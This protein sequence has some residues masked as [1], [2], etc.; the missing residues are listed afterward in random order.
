MIYN[1]PPSLIEIAACILCES[2]IPENERVSLSSL[3]SAF[4]E[5][6]RE[7]LSKPFGSSER[8]ASSTNARLT[9]QKHVGTSAGITRNLLG[10]NSKLMKATGGRR[11]DV[12][13]L[14]LP[15][16]SGVETIGLALAPAY[17]HGKFKL[18]PN[19]KSCKASCL[20]KTSGGYHFLGGGSDLEAVKGPR[21]HYV[22]RTHALLKNP[23]EF[24]IRLYDEISAA[25][26]VAQA[27][28]NILGVRLNVL[29]DIHPKVYKSLIEA[30]PEVQ[31]YDYTKNNAE[32]I[33]P[34]HH[35]TYSST[36]VSQYKGQNG[37]TKDVENPHQNWHLMRTRLENGNNVAM[38][39][40]H[41]A[42]IPKKVVDD[43]TGKEY[44]VIDGNAHDFTPLHKPDERG[45]GHIIGLTNK[46]AT[47]SNANAT[48]KSDGFFVHYDPQY[49]TEGGRQVKDE[50]GRSIPT[51]TVVH[52]AK[53]KRKVITLDNDSN[54]VPF[55][56]QENQ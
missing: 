33:A 48:E 5:A 38:V 54:K 25:K 18:C 50:M 32:T 19:A 29:S 46:A 14:T 42:E 45:I 20:G 21:V 10:Q 13:P 4:D 8:R 31:F 6:L 16:G 49:L 56:K 28:G 12:D 37:L 24:A 30:H 22:N 39:F 41:K 52:I 34:N 47:T 9:I 55:G 36:G 40:S 11:G 43:E 3:Q 15:D 44:N 35:L 26:H 23:K 1:L 17:E 53:Q 27:N 2:R 7:H 51:N